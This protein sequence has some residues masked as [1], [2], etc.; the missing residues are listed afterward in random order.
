MDSVWR[1][2]EAVITGLTRN[3]E[4]MLEGFQWQS[5]DFQGLQGSW[6]SN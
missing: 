6:G 5:L 4:S 3:R 1:R 2:I